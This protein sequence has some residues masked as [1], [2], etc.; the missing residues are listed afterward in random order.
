MAS[1]LGHRQLSPPKCLHL[2]AKVRGAYCGYFN[3]PTH[4]ISMKFELWIL[5]KKFRPYLNEARKQSR[6]PYKTSCLKHYTLDKEMMRN[7]VWYDVSH[8][9]K[10]TKGEALCQNIMWERCYSLLYNTNLFVL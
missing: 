2:T 7:I 1:W 3:E 4:K 6:P 5:T 8:I 10:S 9:L